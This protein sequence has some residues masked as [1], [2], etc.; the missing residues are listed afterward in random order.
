MDLLEA[1][2]AATT[3]SF[4]PCRRRGRPARSERTSFD[5][6]LV[7]RLRATVVRA[8]YCSSA[9]SPIGSTPASCEWGARLLR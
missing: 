8:W 4:G 3:A 7:A 9:S 6:C 1:H 2:G 5:V